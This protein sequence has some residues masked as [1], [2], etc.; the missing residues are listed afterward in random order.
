MKKSHWMKIIVSILILL[1]LLNF[2]VFV[3]KS[4]V[5]RSARARDQVESILVSS[6][7]KLLNSNPED[8]IVSR[9]TSK[10]KTVVGIKNPVPNQIEIQNV[11]YVN[12]NQ[13]DGKNIYIKFRDKNN[14]LLKVVHISD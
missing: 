11:I 6:G 14:V 8:N 13:I 3:N 1:I 4:D 10:W 7:Y 2:L 12:R 9:S 5:D